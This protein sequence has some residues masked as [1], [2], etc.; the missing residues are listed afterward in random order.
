MTPLDERNNIA[1][2]SDSGSN[3]SNN[4]DPDYSDSGSDSDDSD[5]ESSIEADKK[6]TKENLLISG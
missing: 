6:N 1:F 3:G 5:V 2:D 4:S